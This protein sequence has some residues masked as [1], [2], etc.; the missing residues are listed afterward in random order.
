MQAEVYAKASGVNVGEKMVILA[1]R[2]YAL[3][4]FDAPNWL[5]LRVAFFL[6]LTQLGNDD[7]Q[8]GLDESL[9]YTALADV[10]P[11]DRY[12]I[13]LKNRN[14]ILPMTNGADF[15]GFSNESGRHA[16]AGDSLLVSSDSGVGTTNANFWRPANANF[17]TVGAIITT[18]SHERA[19]SR[20]GVQQHFPQNNTAAGGYTVL[21]GLQLLRDSTTSNVLRCTIKSVGHS[22]DMGYSD[23]P[24]DDALQAALEVWPTTL[25]Q[26]GPVQFSVFNQPAFWFYWPYHKSRLRIHSLGMLKAS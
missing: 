7:D 26:L 2:G 18:G 20:D 15:I 4:P 16:G 8:T 17:S 21:L 11:Q 6:S 23:N 1:T 10:P 3:Y 24:T 14:T 13:G 19:I 12:W 25:Q 5:D 22:A 9:G